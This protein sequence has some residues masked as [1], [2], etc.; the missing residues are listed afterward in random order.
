MFLFMILLK[1]R[2]PSKWNKV[3]FVSSTQRV[4]VCVWGIQVGKTK[5][6]RDSVFGEGEGLEVKQSAVWEVG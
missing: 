4:C 2:H 1:W 5:Y 6:L 3:L